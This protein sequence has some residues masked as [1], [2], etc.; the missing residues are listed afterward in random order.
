MSAGYVLMPTASAAPNSAIKT[1]NGATCSGPHPQGQGQHE[2]YI[3]AP[4]GNE[5]DRQ[6]QND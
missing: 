2:L 5:K 1:A 4:G 6:Q 3:A